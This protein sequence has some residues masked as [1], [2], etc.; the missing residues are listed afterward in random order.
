MLQV[1]WALICAVAFVVTMYVMDVRSGAKRPLL[2]AIVTIIAMSLASFLAV[3][4]YTMGNA[5]E[6]ARHATPPRLPAR[7][8]TV[9]VAPKAGLDRFDSSRHKLIFRSATQSER[10]K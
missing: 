3:I 8:D 9:I 6:F 4:V 10:T 2:K 5:F 1:A 7:P